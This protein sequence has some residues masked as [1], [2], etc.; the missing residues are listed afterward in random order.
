MAAGAEQPKVVRRE[1]RIIERPRL[2]KLLD[3]S[4]ARTI[5][6]LA[7]AGYGKTTLARQWAKTLSRVVWVTLTAA[8]R[9]VAWLAEDIAR[10]LD[11]GEGASTRLI[12]EH[13][14][15]RTNPQR[16][17]SELGAKLAEFLD[18]A[19][20]RWLVLD[21]YHLLGPSGEAEDLIAK[22][23][24]QI[25]AHVLVASRT[26]PS[27][28]SG[29][30][31]V[32]GE[33]FE[34]TRAELAMNDEEVA[35]VIGRKSSAARLSEQAAGWPAV[36][37]L[38]A[39]ANR[40]VVPESAV[41]QALHR[42]L[43]EELFQRATPELQESL[44]ALVLRRPKTDDELGA[45]LGQDFEDLLVE[46]ESLGFSSSATQ[47]DLHPLLEEFLLEK[48]ATLPDSSER[49][50]DAV[51]GNLKD[52]AWDR[53]LSLVCRFE[54]VDLVEPALTAAFRPL[55]RSGR[56]A[57]LGVFARTV[58]GLAHE[59]PACIDAVLADV[60]FRDGHLELALDLA[61]AARSRLPGDSPMLSRVAAI[62]GQIS[63]LKAN[64][65]EAEE[66]FRQARQSASDP[67]DAA[68]AAYGLASASIFGE[69]E[70]AA[71]A[72]AALR[73]V[74]DRTPVDFL[75]FVC[76]E[77][78]LRLLGHIESGLRD[79]LHLDAAHELLD[80]AEDPR[81][82][83][84]LAYT[85]ASALTQRGEYDSAREW[86]TRF[87]ADA[88]EFGLEFAMPYANWTLAQIALGQRRFGEAERVLQ[89]I[90]D[91]AARSSEQHHVLNVKALRARLLLQTGNP[92]AALECVLREPGIPLIPSWRAEYLAS[93]ALALACLGRTDECD[94][95]AIEATSLSAAL[96]VRGLVQGAR[97]ICTLDRRSELITAGAALMADAHRVDVWD[98]VICAL[99]SAPALGDAIA[100]IADLRSMLEALYQRS[101]DLHL[102]RRAGF[103][104][105]A[106][107][108]PREI[109]SP[110]E[111]EILNLIASGYKNSEISRALFIADSTTKV[112]VRH[113]LEKLGVR[114]RA[115][116]AARLRMYDGDG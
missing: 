95:A 65:V 36:I 100:S 63:F 89:A 84:S 25:G 47:F 57:T 51:A 49:V 67:R 72:V 88:E 45:E 33:I 85:A 103:R 59:T 112:H 7:P 114:T 38:A 8:H 76:S 48:L 11:R 12:Q 75:R 43:A 39:A 53:A 56:L 40:A 94:R 80:R 2:I 24:Q 66:A 42:Y 86:L 29:R 62:I 16:S 10:A 58:R 78:S 21:D 93:R 34:V 115:E 105:R 9:D 79:G 32:Y 4:D 99:R 64:F 107:R 73:K 110:R 87:F 28:A 101:G 82:R 68:E 70:G 83:T 113:I 35:A 102:A 61:A 104:T 96:Q 50:R 71:E 54:R 116:A 44:L 90:E 27:W 22:I 106:T 6:L 74:R 26:R 41:P 52:E 77:I 17:S 13:I 91:G 14:R 111:Y 55:S 46:A 3:D 69:Q 108:R 23:E 109:L 30:R 98:P 20:T 97:S 60:A 37:G 19:D 5:L 92:D 81:A 15:A 31:L 18:D 1:Q